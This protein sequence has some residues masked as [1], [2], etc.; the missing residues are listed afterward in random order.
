VVVVGAGQAGLAA[1]YHLAQRGLRFVI[2]DSASEL[3]HS[4]R[5]RWD[6]LRLFTPAQY[7][8][9]PGM[10]FPAAA[11]TYPSK[12][13]VADYVKA[14]AARFDLPVMLGTRVEHLDRDPAPDGLFRVATS[15]GTLWARQVVVATGPFQRPLIPSVSSAFGAGVTQTHSSD[16]SNPTPLPTG[17]ALV[18]GAG[19]SGLQIALELSRTR[20][21]HLAVGT[22]QKAVAQRPLGRDLFWWLTKTGLIRRPV[23]SPIAA[24]FRKRGGDLVIGTT[25][26]DIDA[27]GITVHPRLTTAI[28]HTA[29]FSDGSAVQQVDTVVWATGFRSDYAWLDVPDVWDGT[30]VHHSRGRTHVPGLWFV[31]LPWQH[32]RGSALLGFVGDDASWVAEQV[33]AQ[34]RAAARV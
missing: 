18:V 12:D 7:D 9:L 33:V 4:W 29:G 25:W 15:Q 1:G 32:T 19:N 34:A 23:T 27:A 22:R 28:G 21:V 3:G 11:D 26:A 10:P 20:E 2:V 24:W 31:G 6:S 16:Y 14:Y 17:K 30:H 5:V 13:E 8:G